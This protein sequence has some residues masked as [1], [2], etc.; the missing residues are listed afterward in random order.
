MDGCSP[1]TRSDAF[2]VRTV[3]EWKHARGIFMRFFLRED[4][5]FLKKQFVGTRNSDG[6]TLQLSSEV[7]SWI[8]NVELLERNCGS[9]DN[10]MK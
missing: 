7:K 9:L 10:L 1:V 2:S 8:S 3:N 4:M 6:I 5:V